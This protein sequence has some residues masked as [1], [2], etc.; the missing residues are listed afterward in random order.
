M[1]RMQT[2]HISNSEITVLKSIPKIIQKAYQRNKD[3]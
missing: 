1:I 2:G 3:Q